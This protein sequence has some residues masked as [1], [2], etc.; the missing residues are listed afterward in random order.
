MLDHRG[1]GRG[2]VLFHVVRLPFVLPRAVF[3]C[4]EYNE[5]LATWIP[6]IILLVMEGGRGGNLPSIKV[7]GWYQIRGC[8]F[9]YILCAIS[10]EEHMEPEF[11]PIFQILVTF[12]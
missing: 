6:W 4:R 11:G 3:G 8:I 10:R 1:R 12:F 2:W 5:W 7:D 9:E